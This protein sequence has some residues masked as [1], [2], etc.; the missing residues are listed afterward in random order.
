VL[1]LP[2]SRWLSPRVDPF[3]L[4]AFLAGADG[5]SADFAR[6]WPDARPEVLLRLTFVT[7]LPTICYRC[8]GVSGYIRYLKLWLPATNV[9]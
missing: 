6:C 5:D 4:P 7:P 2:A 8:N 9:N 3:V 1:R